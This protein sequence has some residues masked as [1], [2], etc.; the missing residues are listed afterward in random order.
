M[1]DRDE[2]RRDEDTVRELARRDAEAPSAAVVP[3]AG[4]WGANTVALAGEHVKIMEGLRQVFL[5]YL[6][7]NDIVR[8]GKT[9]Y[10]TESACQKA[11]QIYGVSLRD[12]HV[13]QNTYS[14]E[15]GP[16]VTFFATVTATFRDRAIT[17][18]GSAST[19]DDF[20]NGTETGPD[21][22]RRPRRLPLSEIDVPNVRKKAATN[23][24][25]RAIRKILGLAFTWDELE[26][27]FRS[28]GKTTGGIA[29]VT[30]GGKSAEKRAT[31]RGA[32]SAIKLKLANA[33]L[34]LA[35]G[36]T[37]DARDLLRGY[38]S[39]VDKEGREKFATSVRD[40]TDRWAEST[41]GKVKPDHEAWLR[42]HPTPEEPPAESEVSNG[43]E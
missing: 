40:M 1:R 17:E 2:Y 12:T 27:A 18:I 42:D 34:Q 30:Y 5:G 25:G 16:V 3:V 22:Q 9:P 28:R 6:T 26:A 24:M 7:P 31:G 35:N 32:D 23:A 29:G 33:V 43:A 14:D 36:S 13:E 21:G 4:E 41:W 19:A 38:S 20:V 11:A 8:L 39:F 37:E 15:R 10:L